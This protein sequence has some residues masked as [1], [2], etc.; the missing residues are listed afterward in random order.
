MI[1]VAFLISIPLLI[2]ISL[3]VFGGGQIFM[4][5]FRWL[6]TFLSSVFG[7]QISEEKINTVF[8]VSNSTPG[9]VSTKF[10]FFTGFLT[11]YSDDGS[12]LW[13]GYVAMFVTYFFFCLPAIIIMLLAMRYIKK[14]KNNSFVKNMLIILRPIISGIIFSLVLQLLVQIFLPEIEFNK[15]SIKYFSYTKTENNFFSG[16][17]GVLL[18]IY[19]PLGILISYYLAKKKFS[20]FL[21]ILLNVC[22]SFILFAI[23][24][25]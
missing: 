9:V 23:P 3:S 17:K 25:V 10:G 18:K 8:A 6:W 5:I 19:V 2:L 13:W 21:I 20:L 15:N 7:S 22:V 12:V 24:Y 4:P 11:A 14:F 16:Y 1:F